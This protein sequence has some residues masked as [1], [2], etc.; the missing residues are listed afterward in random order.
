MWTEAAMKKLGFVT[1]MVLMLVGATAARADDAAAKQA[2]A[3]K[4]ID[5]AKAKGCAGVQKYLAA[6]AKACPDEA[7]EAK[8]IVCSA[9]EY[10][11][12]QALNVRCADK[13]KAGVGKKTGG[14]ATTTPATPATTP[15]TPA[16]D[17]PAAGDKN[18]CKA[19]DPADGSVIAQD[20]G[21]KPGECMKKLKEAVT[22]LKCPAAKKFKYSFVRGT[23]KPLFQLVI[24]K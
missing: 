11:R 8:P 13:L 2:E 3:Q 17:A 24:C 1:V 23:G 22:R 5:E 7:A 19:L 6:Q 18:S 16:N 15:A 4:K 21:T 20:T 10:A 12:M 14:P 9:A